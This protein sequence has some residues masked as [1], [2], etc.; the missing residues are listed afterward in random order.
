MSTR[1]LTRRLLLPCL[2]CCLALAA[3]C[4]AQVSAPPPRSPLAD[5]AT[6]APDAALPPL[7]PLPT[8]AS[9][10][11]GTSAPASSGLEPAAGRA[12]ALMAEWLALP[13]RDLAV[14]AVEAIA[15]PDA[16]LGVAQPGIVCA[17]IITPG[18]KVLLRDPAGG[19][20]AVHADATG[21]RARWA[22]EVT[23]RGTVEAVD[24]ASRRLTVTVGGRPLLLRLAPGTSIPRTP[25]VGAKVVLAYDPAPASAGPSPLA[26]LVPDPS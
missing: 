17:S 10:P 22:G 19:T 8:G 14:L 16:C 13:E 2:G 15:W 23:V 7:P 26:W 11:L 1:L 20:H 18:F 9:G 25:A 12:A 5:T 21:S 3:G 6:V 4:G 24:T